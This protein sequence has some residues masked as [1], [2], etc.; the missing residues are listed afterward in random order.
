MPKVNRAPDFA[1]TSN[2]APPTTL[3]C[4]CDHE[5]LL[6]L[7]AEST[8]ARQAEDSKAGTLQYFFI[9]ILFA[10]LVMAAALATSN[11]PKGPLAAYDLLPERERRPGLPQASL[12]A[13][14]AQDCSEPETA[15]CC[16]QRLPAITASRRGAYQQEQDQQWARKHCPSKVH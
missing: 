11:A 16:P 6:T 4:S 15:G 7:E 2:N 3:H 12:L 9:G 13:R 5:P 14:C 8:L 1:A 10:R